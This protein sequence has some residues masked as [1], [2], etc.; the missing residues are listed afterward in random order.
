[1]EVRERKLIL[2]CDIGL[3]AGAH[4]GI[5]NGLLIICE[6]D[7]T[8]GSADASDRYSHISADEIKALETT[9]LFSTYQRYDLF[10]SHGSGAYLFDLE[11]R[12][13]LDF[14]AG[15]AVNSLGYNH[16]RISKVLQEQG[17]KLIHCSNLLY[18]A[19]Q[20]QLAK[21]LVELTGMARVFFTNSGTEAIEAALKIARAFARNQ[22]HEG[23]SRFVCV[24]NSFHGRTFGALSITS[25][26]K[27]QAPFR[28]LLAEVGVVPELSAE[29]LARAFDDRVCALVLEPIQ[30]E[31]GVRALTADF[32]RTARELCDRYGALLILDEIQTGFARTGRHFA[33]QHFQVQPDLLTLAKAIASGYPLGAVVGNARVGQC[34]KPGEHGTTYGGGPLACR[35]ALEALD[36]IEDEG[37][38]ARAEELGAYLMTRLKELKSRHRSISEVRG[39]GLMIGVEVGSIAPEAVKKLLLRGVIA[40]ASHGTVLRLV[41]PLIITSDQIDVFVDALDHV[42]DELENG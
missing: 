32:L 16:P 29:A 33:F 19:Y 8:M 31:A 35:V 15:I 24:K 30:G 9:Y 20:G 27:Y 5:I 41:P 21:R 26:E 18:H 4:A 17:Q 14:L 23:K 11:G 2:D 38:A 25:Q 10:L 12:R 42:L 37:L 1:L 39:L 40:N 3:A 28:P 13:Y 7:E 36:V 6:G 22:G 34:L